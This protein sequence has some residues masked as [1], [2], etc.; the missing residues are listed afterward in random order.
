[1][2]SSQKSNR[3]PRRDEDDEPEKDEELIKGDMMCKFLLSFLS[4]L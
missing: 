1:M 2:K 3:K 4:E